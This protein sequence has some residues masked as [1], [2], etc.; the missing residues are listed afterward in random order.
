[1]AAAITLKG[2]AF[3]AYNDYDFGN[4]LWGQAGKQLG[5]GL[6]SVIFGSKFNN[7]FNGRENNFD[8]KTGV[9]DS[10]ADQEAITNGYLFPMGGSF[11]PKI[12]TPSNPGLRMLPGGKM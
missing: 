11:R 6:G 7:L 4:F 9:F 2:T 8:L 12:F 5:F 1:M 10:N 3:V